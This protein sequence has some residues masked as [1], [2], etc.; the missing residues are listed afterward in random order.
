MGEKVNRPAL[1][2][3]NAVKPGAGS[4]R[5]LPGRVKLRELQPS[6]TLLADD[7]QLA[8]PH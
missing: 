7:V 5:R 6:L 2:A 1:E 4:L 8:P 3:E